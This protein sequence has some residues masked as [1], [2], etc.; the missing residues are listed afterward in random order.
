MCIPS[1]YVLIL[2]LCSSFSGLPATNKPRLPSFNSPPATP[3]TLVS[4]KSLDS[5]DSGHSSADDY[6][7]VSIALPQMYI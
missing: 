6:F 4:P 1:T 2:S 3:H 5:E 7:T